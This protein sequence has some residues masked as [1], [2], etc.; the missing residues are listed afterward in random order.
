MTFTPI[1]YL[2]QNWHIPLN[3]ALSD[4]QAQ[5]SSLQ[6]SVVSFGAVGNGTTNDSA[7]IQNAITAVQL[8]GGG[9]VFFPEGIYQC[10]STI[11]VGAR[12]TLVGA[13][14]RSSI[15]RKG[16][17][18]VLINMSGPSTD[19]TGATHVR[20]AGLRD[21]GLN[22]NGLSG[23][24]LQLFYADNLSFQ[25]VYMSSNA[26]V[27]VD[28]AEFWDSRFLNCQFESSG[29]A[30]DSITPMVR[31]R[32]SA[33]ASGF[34]FS[35]DNTNQIVFDACR[36]EDF[37]NGALRIE[38][39]VNN[40]NA[41]NG[42][43]IT[44]CKMETSSMRGGAHLLASAACRAVWVDGLY[45]FAGNF[46]SGYSTAQN[47]IV[48]SPQASVLTNT[49]IANGSVATINSAVDL[50]SGAASTAVLQNVVGSYTTAPTG[51]HVFFEASSTADFFLQNVYSSSGSTFGGTIPI[52]F[53]GQHP[54]KQVAGAVTD[55]SFTHTPLSGALGLDTTNNRL[56][57]RIGGVWFYTPM[58]S[59]GDFSFAGNIS[60]TEIGSGL[61]VAEGANAKMGV[62]TLV[63]GSSVV[64]TT[65]VTANS[66]ILVTSQVDGGTPGFLRVS[67]RSAGTN[68]TIAS[69]SGAD[70]STVAWM[71]VE[72]A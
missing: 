60:V 45:C 27:M 48:W 72:P 37:N 11:N 61:R 56:Y 58:S 15:L 16:S 55:A 8:A 35:A 50:F 3:A 47:I 43:A 36:W 7:A 6:V 9:E 54:I 19:I 5:V 39:G 52:R 34:G 53:A 59:T 70:T 10:N 18:G 68:F 44:N 46:F 26:D 71:L 41:P 25:N 24:L 21:I 13:G 33:A 49:L 31:M 42:F 28:S 65:A 29:G 20:Y 22:G 62:T 1:D 30:A 64:A 38:Q 69:S 66:R 4:L 23:L 2:T 32:N 63:A 51:A 57:A 17:A 12:V 14:R 40:T 67:T